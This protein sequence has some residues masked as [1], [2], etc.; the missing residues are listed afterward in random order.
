MLLYLDCTNGID[1]DRLVAALLDLSGARPGARGPLDKVVRPALKA[2]GIDPRLATVEAVRRDGEAALVFG[3]AD[4]P[5]FASFDELIMSMYA[6]GVGQAVA[7]AVAAVADRL[8]AAEGA[9]YGERD[10]RH[11]E[12]SGAATAVELIAAAALVHDLAPERV[13][14]SPPA[15][16]AGAS[17]AGAPGSGETS[18]D[19]AAVVVQLLHGLPVAGRDDDRR[20]ETDVD[21]GADGDAEAVAKGEP[22]TPSGAALLAQFA[23][24]FGAAPAGA[25][26][27]RGAGAARHARPGG[28]DVLRVALIDAA[29]EESGAP[30]AGVGGRG[31]AGGRPGEPEAAVVADAPEAAAGPSSATASAPGLPPA[32]HVV[33]ETN[34]DDMS[35]ELLSHAAETLREAGALDV[36][37]T[38]ALMKKGRP[39]TVLHVLAA[40]DDRERLAGLVFAETTTFGVRVVP[41]GRLYA[42]E[43]RETVRIAGHDIGVRLAFA[44][45]RLATVSPE[46]EDCRRAAADLGRPARVVYEAAQAR[47]RSR[48]SCV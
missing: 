7:D 8:R 32:D 5:G 25:V 38:P 28:A 20:M 47:A 3:V 48:F 33:L 13:V 16:G 21:A 41:A 14:A 6:S 27:R 17:E 31:A 4:A 39:G 46:Y 18:F 9:V 36:W 15:L 37:M 11:P 45:G 23:D 40:A 42:E 29:T 2:A 34:I 10:E 1:G 24:A 22:T 12:L 19:A 43:R 44:H 30:D 35:A 26:V